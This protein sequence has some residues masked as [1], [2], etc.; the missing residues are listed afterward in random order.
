MHFLNLFVSKSHETMGVLI[1]YYFTRCGIF[2][3]QEPMEL[4]SMSTGAIDL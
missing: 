2:S 3:A 1:S 4:G